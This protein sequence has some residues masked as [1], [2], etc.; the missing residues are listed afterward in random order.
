MLRKIADQHIAPRWLY[1]TMGI[2]NYRECN[3]F[4]FRMFEKILS[5]RG[6]AVAFSQIQ[7]ILDS[8]VIYSLGTARILRAER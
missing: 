7:L 8:L 3:R 1:S 2:S 4:V 5:W 6:L